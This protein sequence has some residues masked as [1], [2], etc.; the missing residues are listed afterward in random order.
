MPYSLVTHCA[1]RSLQRCPLQLSPA[2]RWSCWSRCSGLHVQ[3]CRRGHSF[4]G[5]E[6]APLLTCNSDFYSNG[7]STH[8]KTLPSFSSLLSLTSLLSSEYFLSLSHTRGFLS[9]SL[10][11]RSIWAETLY[12]PFLIIAQCLL[13]VS[14]HLT[15]INT[16]CE[17]NYP[18]LNVNCISI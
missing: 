18:M 5:G 2:R 10:N 17:L 15:Q 16:L 4:P 3:C 12:F 13:H 6:K 1:S 11:K 8:P 14:T 9:P 7:I